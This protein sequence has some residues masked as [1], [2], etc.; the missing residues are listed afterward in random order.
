MK[1]RRKR[2]AATLAAVTVV[3]AIASFGLAH[4][5]TDP[6]GQPPGDELCAGQDPC[7][8]INGAADPN[9][10]EAESQLVSPA[11]ALDAS[12]RPPSACPK[13]EE[14]YEDVGVNPD[15]IIGPC[16]SQQE[17]PSTEASR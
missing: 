10:G 7:V 15:A 14:A 9:A 12:G 5:A 6:A 8:I 1:H 17:L 4:A 16:P 11:A 3:T 2:P 13:A